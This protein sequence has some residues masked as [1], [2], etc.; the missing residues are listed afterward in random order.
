MPAPARGLAGLARE[1][2][3]EVAD[4]LNHLETCIH[5]KLPPLVM[6]LAQG[7]KGEAANLIRKEIAAIKALIRR[8]SPE[9]MRWGGTGDRLR[10]QNLVHNF[11]AQ[12]RSAELRQEDK[13]RRRFSR[14]DVDLPVTVSHGEGCH[15]GRAI[16]V[17]LEGM[18]VCSNASHRV[19]DTVLLDVEEGLPLH[20]VKGKVV[21]SR[22][23]EAGGYEAGVKFT[24]L[25]DETRE[26]IR[27]FLNEEQ[28]RREHDPDALLA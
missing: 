22:D 23:A 15:R 16:N 11:D 12:M 18:R 25:D 9:V 6:L 13:E 10:Y 1:K 27:R 19:G 28:E 7:C 20:R 17:N 14:L 24:A 2:R 3:S 8:L 26:L 4:M 21:W 5:K